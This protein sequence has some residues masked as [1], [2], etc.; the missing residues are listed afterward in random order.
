M[1][2]AGQILD[3]LIPMSRLEGGVLIG[4]MVFGIWDMRCGILDV[5]PAPHQVRGKLQR[6][7]RKL[8]VFVKS[9][10]VQARSFKLSLNL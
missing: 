8:N 7:S 10:P 6:E 1:R 4:D 5:I 2:E 3:D 9:H